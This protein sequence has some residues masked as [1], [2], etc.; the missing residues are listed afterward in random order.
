VLVGVAQQSHLPAQHLAERDGLA[1]KNGH[2]RAASHP[3]ITR[4]SGT[5]TE[6]A[7]ARSS[8]ATTALAP[9]AVGWPCLGLGFMRAEGVAR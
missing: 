8:A 4:H 9:G 3:V 2:E 5:L 1:V 6:R 7:G